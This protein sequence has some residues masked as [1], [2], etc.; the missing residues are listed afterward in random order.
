M[1]EGLWGRARLPLRGALLGAAAQRGVPWDQS[2]GRHCT[3]Q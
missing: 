2:V 1:R 3:E